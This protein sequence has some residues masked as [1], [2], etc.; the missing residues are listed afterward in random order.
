MVLR[1]VPPERRHLA[2][3]MTAPAVEGTAGQWWE[4]VDAATDPR[5]PAAAVALTDIVLGGTVEVTALGVHEEDASEACDELLQALLAALRHRTVDTVVMR[6][7]QA[8][9]VRALLAAGFGLD[10]DVDDRYLI[11]L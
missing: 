6:S 7:T 4:W 1:R 3:A 11:A 8:R 9:V 2:K 5:L 10:P